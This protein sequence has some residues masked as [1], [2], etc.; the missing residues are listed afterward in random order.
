MDYLTYIQQRLAQ[1]RHMLSKKKKIKFQLQTFFPRLKDCSRCHLL[2]TS[3]ITL[4]EK[5]KNNNLCA[6]FVTF[7]ISCTQIC[8]MFSVIIAYEIFCISVL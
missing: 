5:N 6:E 8:K 3:L 2:G 7:S 1:H 4:F